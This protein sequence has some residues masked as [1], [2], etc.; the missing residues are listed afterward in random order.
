MFITPSFKKSLIVD[1]FQGN[2]LKYFEEAYFTEFK[3]LVLQINPQKC[4]WPQKILKPL[5]NNF[6][7]P[8]WSVIVRQTEPGEVS[9]KVLVTKFLIRG[10]LTNLYFFAV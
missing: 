7:G 2:Y 10:A 8:K 9:G 6:P 1:Q 4:N 3:R 5:S